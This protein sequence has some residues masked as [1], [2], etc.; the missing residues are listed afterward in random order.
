MHPISNRLKNFFD[1]KNIDIQSLYPLLGYKSPEKIYRLFR[2]TEAKH[3]ADILSDISNTFDNLNM[4][5]IL[6][7]KGSMMHNEEQTSLSEP[8]VSYESASCRLCEDKDRII[9]LLESSL[10]DKDAIISMLKQDNV[11]FHSKKKE[12]NAS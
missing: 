5:W 8:T 7:G 1:S 11:D 6:T 12:R 10:K 3:S 9:S 4:R 2:K